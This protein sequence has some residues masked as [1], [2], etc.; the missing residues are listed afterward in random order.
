MP[1]V[2][3]PL[4]PLAD[5][6]LFPGMVLPLHIFEERYIR[7]LRGVLESDRRFGVCLI[8]QGE[9]VGEPAEP[10]EIGAI[11]HISESKEVS[12]GVYVLVSVGQQRFR[13]RRQ[14]YDG[15][16][17]LAEVETFEDT[18]ATTDLEPLCAR[19]RTLA[20]RH[21]SLIGQATGRNLDPA[22]FPDSPQDLSFVIASG[23]AAD[24]SLR[25]S[26][27]ELTDT[28]ERLEILIGL[29][30]EQTEVMAY[31]IDHADEL[32]RVVGGNGHLKPHHL[33]PESLAS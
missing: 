33:D 26:L 16:L 3:L 1:V 29:L 24:A 13:I 10:F 6:V 18:P 12:P 2:P 19:L 28:Q 7:M 17:I 11:A 27:L 20:D 21:L 23:L 5:V 22:R 8:R 4:F 14:W 30:T 25:Q 31:R 15:K 32:H 9:E